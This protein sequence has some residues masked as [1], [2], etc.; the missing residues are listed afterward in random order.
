[1]GEQPKRVIAALIR[2]GDYH[3]LPDTPSAHQPFPLN[4]R[5]REQAAQA[6]AQIRDL[7]EQHGWQ[8]HPVID[9]SCLLRGWQT[10]RIIADGLGAEYQIESF[11]DLA[12]RG[13]GCAA[14]LSVQKIESILAQD[15]RFESP[16]HNWKADSH[17]QL[18][19]QGAESLLQAGERVARHLR[20]RIDDLKDQV[21]Q[22]CLKLFVGHGAAFRHA[23]FHLDALRFEQ[24]A[25]LS[26]YHCQPLCLESGAKG[27]QAVAGAWKQRRPK[28]E[29]MD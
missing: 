21:Q 5:G 12:E 9:S 2:H 4:A 6:V 19:L 3:Q 11:D 16:P 18:P 26:M 13:L 25:D 24:I 7:T 15:P 17:Y 10:A 23:A 29:A 1:M 22:D 20:Q 27:W 28:E 8:L 14:N